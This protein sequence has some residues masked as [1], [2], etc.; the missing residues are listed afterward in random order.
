MFP[1]GG[2]KGVL[3]KWLVQSVN[4]PHM[5]R[6]SSGRGC[7]SLQLQPVSSRGQ[8]CRIA[9]LYG[10]RCYREAAMAVFELLSTDAP[11]PAPALATAR[12]QLSVSTQTFESACVSSGTI[13]ISF[14]SRLESRRTEKAT[15]PHGAMKVTREENG[16]SRLARS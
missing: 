10:V 5:H 8:P 12:R 6:M 3:G 2:L 1:E 4:F 7:Q 11:A 15:E 16:A 9:A 13:H 14:D